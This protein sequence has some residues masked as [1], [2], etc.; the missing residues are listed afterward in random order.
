[1]KN[2]VQLGDTI[3]ANATRAIASGEGMLIG[4]LFGVAAGTYANG[5]EGEFF[6]GQGVVRVA[7]VPANTGAVGV[8]MYWDNTAFLL[9]TT[10]GTNTFVGILTQ[11]KAAGETTATVRLNGVAV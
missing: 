4:T 1:M 8:K 9:T 7:A 2:K 10:V 11:A 3:T 6:V 5:A